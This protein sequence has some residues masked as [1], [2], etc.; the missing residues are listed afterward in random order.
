L[1]FGADFGAAARMRARMAMLLS[2]PERRQSAG[3]WDLAVV[4]GLPG[5]IM[6]LRAADLFR[7]G[8]A[9]TAW[10]S[11]LFSVALCAASGAAF[12]AGLRDPT[13]RHHEPSYPIGFGPEWSCSGPNAR[14]SLCVHNHPSPAP[15]SH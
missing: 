8:G 13:N 9:A 2:P 10:R 12:V 15:A 1:R 4:F 6:A 7:T 14:P 11:G 5:A 3:M